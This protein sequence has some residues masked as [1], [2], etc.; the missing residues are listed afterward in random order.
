MLYLDF[1]GRMRNF[2]SSL[3]FAFVFFFVIL[4]LVYFERFMWVTLMLR[5]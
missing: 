5:Q 1:M 3:H 2:Y 4:L